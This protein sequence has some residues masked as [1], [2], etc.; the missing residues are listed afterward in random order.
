MWASR[1]LFYS[2]DKSVSHLQYSN[3]THSPCASKIYVAGGVQEGKSKLRADARDVSRQL[4]VLHCGLSSLRH[5]L[6]RQH[7][8]ALQIKLHRVVPIWAC[9]SEHVHHRNTVFWERSNMLVWALADFAFWLWRLHL[10][11]ALCLQVPC[12]GEKH[13]GGT[14]DQG[15][16]C[17][18]FISFQWLIVLQIS[19][20]AHADAAHFAVHVQWRLTKQSSML[21]LLNSSRV[22]QVCL[23][24]FTI[25]TPTQCMENLYDCWN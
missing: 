18:C 25:G 16:L 19:L 22:S 3:H 9:P 17:I 24:N 8:S 20:H 14:F 21:F 7:F 2:A 5:R 11:L 10:K 23:A 13:I 15:S 6:C 1:W 12:K 4:F